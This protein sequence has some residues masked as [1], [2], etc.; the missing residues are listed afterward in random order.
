M[1]DHL[2]KAEIR[3]DEVQSTVVAAAGAV[4]AVTTILTAVKDV[5]GALGGFA[6]E[7]FE[8]RDSVRRAAADRGD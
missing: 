4:G 5:T 7:L 2:S 8:V 6:T 3:K 1:P